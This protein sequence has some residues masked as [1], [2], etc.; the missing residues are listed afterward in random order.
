MA[1]N[2]VLPL[3]YNDI[4]G[5]TKTWTDEEFGAYMRL[6][7][8]QWDKGGLPKDSQRLARLITSMDVTWPMIKDKFEEIDGMLKNKRMEEVREEKAR[9]AKKQKEN[10]EKRYQNP[11]KHIAKVLA[12]HM[13]LEGEGEGEEESKILK[14]VGEIEERLNRAMDDKTLGDIR[15][16]ARMAYPGV[17]LEK[18]FARFKVKVKTSPRVYEG[19]DTESLRLALNS[20][21]RGAL[22]EKPKQNGFNKNIDHVAGLAEDFAKRHGAKAD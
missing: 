16:N 3:Y 20:H 9:H 4:V 19:R 6:L 12:K 7:I 22:P 18:E 5:S 13:P 2:P 1:K 10:A 21:L 17:D 14:G 8:E 15:V 11:A